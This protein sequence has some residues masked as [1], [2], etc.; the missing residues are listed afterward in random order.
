VAPDG[1]VRIETLS[2]TVRAHHLVLAT[3]TP[4][5]FAL[6]QTEVAPYRSYVIARDGGSAFPPGLF[7]D[8]ADP[9]HYLRPV[10]IDGA[11]LVLIGGG[12]HKTGQS[13]H[14]QTR[15]ADLE[16]YGVQRLGIGTVRRQWS[17]QLYEPAD[18]L[19]YVGALAGSD[20]VHVA[21]GLAGT[22]LVFGTMAAVEL[23]ASLR[24][25]RRREYPFDA[26]RLR[27]AAVPR[28]LSENANVA[29]CWIGDR[30]AAGDHRFFAAVPQGEGRIVRIEGKRRAVFRSRDGFLHVLSAVC[31]HMGG[32]VRW[33]PVE[34][35]WDCPCHGARFAPT[36]EVLEGPALSDLERQPLPAAARP[37][38]ARETAGDEARD[39][40]A[41]PASGERR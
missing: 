24:G 2:G 35:S 32:H 21:T 17:A 12:D 8:T 29:A 6:V 16:S 40:P 13:K 20:C 36:G 4:I 15:F 10:E 26:R 38:R 18:G 25:D 3:H 9:Y 7:W 34:Q 1:R 11:A 41:A 31:P 22:G 14:P 30:L 19:P 27:L 37:D 5:G 39:E 33:N 23:A 28:F